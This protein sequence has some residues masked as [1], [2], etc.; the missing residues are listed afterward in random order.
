MVDFVCELNNTYEVTLE[1][2]GITWDKFRNIWVQSCDKN[3]DGNSICNNKFDDCNKLFN[4]SRNY[5]KPK[6]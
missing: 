1:S 3:L 5:P 6:L 2:D 4:D